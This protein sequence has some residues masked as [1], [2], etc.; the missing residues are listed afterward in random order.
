MIVRRPSHWRCSGRSRCPPAAEHHSQPGWHREPQSGSAHLEMAHTVLRP[1]Q[2]SRGIPARLPRHLYPQILSMSHI[3]RAFP[4]P[5]ALKS[6]FL[7][8]LLRVAGTFSSLATAS[9]SRPVNGS[10]LGPD[11][12]TRCTPALKSP[13][14]PHLAGP[15][16]LIRPRSSELSMSWHRNFRSCSTVLMWDQ[17]CWA[18]A[19]PTAR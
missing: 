10:A 18:A 16:T 17:L 11:R 6:M 13:S 8:G 14:S 9:H 1:Y 7:L 19:P 4:Y 12:G 5:S 2:P 15:W 3:L